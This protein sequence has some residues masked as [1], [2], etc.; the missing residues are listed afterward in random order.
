M[1]EFLAGVSRNDAA[2]HDRFWADDLVYTRA[3][4]ERIGKA[5]I[6]RDAKA[7]PA[8]KPGDPQT[9]TPPRT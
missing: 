6:L 5:D 7:A 4:G 3:A 2:V 1:T 9:S 8:P